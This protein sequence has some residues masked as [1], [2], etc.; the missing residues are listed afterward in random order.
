M[1]DQNYD[2]TK[3]L[4][5]LRNLQ[6]NTTVEC[7][8]QTVGNMMCTFDMPSAETAQD[9]IPGALVAV[10]HR[11]CSAMHTTMRATPMQLVFGQDSTLNAQNAAEW[12]CMQ[13]CEQTMI[14]KNNMRENSERKDCAHDPK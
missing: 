11:I 1:I 6:A 10:P 7:A 3:K 14:V 9:Q 13:C 2:V 4:I 5:T 12:K 8:H